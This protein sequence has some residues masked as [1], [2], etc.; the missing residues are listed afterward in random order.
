MLSAAIR[1]YFV[2][3]IVQTGD[4]ITLISQVKVK[5]N[6]YNGQVWRSDLMPK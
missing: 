5:S 6:A 2:Q 1:V 4:L 3:R